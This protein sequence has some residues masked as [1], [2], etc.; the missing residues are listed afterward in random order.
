M[1]G[2]TDKE[3]QSKCLSRFLTSHPVLCLSCLLFFPFFASRFGAGRL[4]ICLMAGTIISQVAKNEKPTVGIQY[5]FFAQ[6][7]FGAVF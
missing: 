1:T 7:A 2:F 5:A 6:N 3:R 4:F